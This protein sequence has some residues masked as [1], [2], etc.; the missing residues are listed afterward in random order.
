MVINYDAMLPMQ[1]QIESSKSLRVKKSFTHVHLRSLLEHLYT[2][3][4][5]WRTSFLTVELEL[6]MTLGTNMSQVYISNLLIVSE[7]DIALSTPI[8]LQYRASEVLSKTI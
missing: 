4:L 5:T 7:N 2:C 1:Q 8:L 3:T 6:T